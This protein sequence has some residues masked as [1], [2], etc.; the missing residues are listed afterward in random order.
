MKKEMQESVLLIGYSEERLKNILHSIIHESFDSIVK[1]NLKSKDD[2]MEYLTIPAS[3]KYLKKTVRTIYNW[4]DQGILQRYY[5]G[6][7]PYLKKSDLINLP[8]SKNPKIKIE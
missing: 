2:E 8:K 5:I 1:G 3:A 4:I 6:D 7:S